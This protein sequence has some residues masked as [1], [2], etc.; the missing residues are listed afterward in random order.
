MQE[1]PLDSTPSSLGELPDKTRMLTS[2]VCGNK[3]TENGEDCD[4]G[5]VQ[6]C[7]DQCCDAATCKLKAGAQCAE[8]ECCSDCKIKEAGEVCR[9]SQDDDCDFE[10][11]CDGKSPWC[12]SDRFQENGAPCMKG[13]GYCYNGSCPTMQR[14]CTSLWGDNTLVGEDLCFNINTKGTVYGYCK[15]VGRTYKPCEPENV[16]CGVLY[17]NS[18]NKY[19][20]VPGPVAVK[21]E[22]KA[23]LVPGGMVQNGI[24]CGDG[25][26]SVHKCRYR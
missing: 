7:K 22:C 6:E 4:C 12:P 11:L 2:P 20:T 24:K 5:T 26:A 25:K 15:K 21:G 16:M 23:L 19:P 17:C 18:D 9:E 1:L 14:Q 8:G 13:E 10:D 3:L